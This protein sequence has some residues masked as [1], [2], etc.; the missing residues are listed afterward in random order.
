VA[1][2]HRLH[3][4]AVVQAQ[5][6][7]RGA[8]CG[9]ARKKGVAS[10]VRA[11]ARCDGRCAAGDAPSAEV[12]SEATAEVATE[13]AAEVAALCKIVQNSIKNVAFLPHFFG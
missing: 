2:Q 12:R 3:R 10:F 11:A 8:A 7:L 4:E 5:Q 13:V 1:Q 9:A 6:Q